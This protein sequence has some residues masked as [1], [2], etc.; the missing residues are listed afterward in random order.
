MRSIHFYIT[1]SRQ[2][3]SKAEALS[4]QFLFY[5]HNSEI[6]NSK[7]ENTSHFDH[8]CGLNL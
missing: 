6:Q 7:G 3:K 1:A 8:E 5:C 4:E 2:N